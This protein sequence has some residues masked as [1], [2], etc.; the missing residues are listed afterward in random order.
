M[1]E[2]TEPTP[3]ENT[4]PIPYENTEP[5]PYENT[6]PTS[7]ENE[8]VENGFILEPGMLEMIENNPMLKMIENIPNIEMHPLYY[9]MQTMQ[10]QHKP[11]TLWLEFGVYKGDS[12]NYISF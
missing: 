2:N 11:D 3:Y 7:Y 6:E 4:E 9:V 12:I 8:F 5:T 1:S 10:L